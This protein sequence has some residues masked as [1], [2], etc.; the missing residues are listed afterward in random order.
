MKLSFVPD[1]SPDSPLLIV[2]HPSKEDLAALREAARDL[3]SGRRDQAVVGA[4]SDSE[5]S[6]VLR[7]TERDIGIRM[8]PPSFECLL[9]RW[10]WSNIEGLIEPFLSGTSGFQWLDDS[11]E[12]SLLL[13]PGG[14]W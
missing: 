5:V 13:S 7:V 11:G 2:S 9:R 8:T 1:G 12:V 10:R 14:T 4:A 3:G 6:L